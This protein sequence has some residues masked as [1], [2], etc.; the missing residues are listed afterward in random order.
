MPLNHYDW[1]ARRQAHRFMGEP[2]AAE[3]L[4]NPSRRG[5]DDLIAGLQRR[6]VPLGRASRAGGT[7]FRLWASFR[8]A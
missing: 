7:A 3:E 2:Q 8:T 1:N 5:V 4:E 6:V